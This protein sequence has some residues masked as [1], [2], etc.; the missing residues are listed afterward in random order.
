MSEEVG[1]VSCIKCR[2][3]AISI[4]SLSEFQEEDQMM[5]MVVCCEQQPIQSF[6]LT[7]SFLFSITSAA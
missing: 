2:R 3:A 5:T 1:E 4:G 7:F 6:V